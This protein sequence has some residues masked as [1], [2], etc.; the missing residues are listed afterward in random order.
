MMLRF[1]LVLNFIGYAMLLPLEEY[2]VDNSDLPLTSFNLMKKSENT[3]YTSYEF[4]FASLIWFD[5]E[6]IYIVFIQ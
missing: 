4:D 1:L 2:A 6:I 3:L 5:G